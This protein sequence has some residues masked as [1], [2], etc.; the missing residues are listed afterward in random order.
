MKYLHA[1][2]LLAVLTI[3][4]AMGQKSVWSFTNKIT[5]DYSKDVPATLKIISPDYL[6]GE[7]RG[8]IK[9]SESRVEIKGIVSH[10]SGVSELLFQD[11][12]VPTSESGYFTVS[13]NYVEGA[14]TLI[15]KIIDNVGNVTQ[16]NFTISKE[17]KG[18]TAGKS[19]YYALVIG[20][21]E[22]D[23][24]NITTLDK[25]IDDAKALYDLLLEKYTFQQE[26]AVLLKNPTRNDILDELDNLSAK[27]TQNDNLLIFYAGHGYWD[28]EAQIGYWLPSD[29]EK[30]RKR[31]WLR[32]NTITDYVK[33]I[34]TKHTLLITDACFGGSIFKT[35]KAFNNASMGVFKL[36]KMVSRKAITSGTLTEVPDESAFMKYLLKKL[37]TNGDKYLTTEQ[38]FYDIKPAVLNNSPSTPQYGVMQGTGDEG[39]DFVFIQK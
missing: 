13:N 33:E 39:G 29:A 14:N 34:D 7:S 25:P 16:K 19:K 17:R 12:V 32:N 4:T 36:N 31:A 8:F 37:N 6:A 15:F 27:V 3:S 26:D 35:R 28:E 22:Y 21:E 1:Y 11:K 23:D 18:A 38:M 2:I 10:P 24:P 9:T 5:V 20:V 30:G